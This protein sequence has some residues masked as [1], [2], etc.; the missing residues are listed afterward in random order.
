ME[1]FVEF[2]RRKV[3]EPAVVDDRARAGYHASLTR[4]DLLRA[5]RLMVTS[6]RLDDRELLLQKQGKAWF[7][8][9][10]A[11]KEA[12]LIAAGFVLRPT[13]PIF[14][15]YRDRALVLTRGFTPREMLLQA[16]AARE[17]PS[18]GGRQMPSHW[19]DPARAV[20]IGL[21]PTGIN[22]LPA[23]GMAEALVKAHLLAE[24]KYPRDAVVY[25][26][27][28]D[29]TCSEGEVYEALKNAAITRAR[30]VFHIEN[31]G[32]GISV[33]LSEQIPGGNPARLF[34][35]I[36][37]LRIIEVDGT[38]FRASFDA[39]RDAAGHARSGAGPVIVHSRV[40]RLYSH[41][42]TDDQRKYRTKS[43][44]ASEQERDP[45][46]RLA[47]ELVAFG[48]A[49]PRELLDIQ[50]QVHH[51]LDALTDE[52]STLPKT[53]VTT[54]ESSAYAAGRGPLSAI[55]SSAG[56]VTVI[57]EAINRCLGELMEADGRIVMWGEDIADFSIRNYRY[58][59]ELDGKGGVFG[60]T[61]GLQ[62][63]FGPER[64]FNAPI[65]EA[66][67]VGRAAGYSLLG[68]LPIVEI[69]FRDYLNPAW[70]QL[71]DFVATMRWRSN[72]A[73]AC[74][75]VIRMSYGGYLGGAGAIWHSEAAAGPLMHHPG[76]RVCVPSNGRDAAGLLREA[77]AS[78]DIVL[79]LEPKALYRRKDE[80]LDVEYPAPDYRVPMGSS[81][82][83]GAGKDLTIVT[84]GNLAPICYRA[85]KELGSA[86][87][88]DLLWLSPLDEDAIRRH[89]A[90]TKRVLVVDEDRRTCGAG[91]AV[92][93]AIL[94]DRALRRKVDVERVAA[95]HCRVSYGPVGERAVLP[96]FD[97]VMAAARAMLS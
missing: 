96:Q 7:A 8:I 39:F 70:Q 5:F 41:S 24:P 52:V 80:F 67:I 33:P 79:F 26:S 56:P 58:K 47:R 29:A 6:R 90:E 49:T 25:A 85:M 75:M 18:S 17:D 15:Y 89:A 61:K 19:G 66:S 42:S 84:Y 81:K 86:R 3:D 20:M 34:S 54:L 53:D 43:D 72:G 9:A 77:A 51:E 31:D 28:G 74:P 64:V 36:L 60:I 57:A 55:K 10:G 59:D 11:G 30:L 76:L 97:D 82:L 35:G 2:L 95:K 71:V 21:S 37:G 12:A 92:V 46:E 68:F 45:L 65:A 44:V 94:K 62:K 88:I 73:F 83:Y 4:D 91:S 50:E 48:I 38:D 78:G 40:V 14:G 32:Y 16:V 63:R 13:D 1:A 23:S 87:M 69:Q 93:D 22:A 27:V